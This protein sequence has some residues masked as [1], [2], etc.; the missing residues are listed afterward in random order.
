VLI[1]FRIFIDMYAEPAKADIFQTRST[2]G[3]RRGGRYVEVQAHLFVRLQVL[4]QGRWAGGKAGQ[5]EGLNASLGEGLAAG[6]VEGLGTGQVEVKAE[7]EIEAKVEGGG[8]ACF[9]V[10]L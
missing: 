9:Q 4:G 5:G 2:P 1:L 8:Q 3:G 10:G 7:A 6:P